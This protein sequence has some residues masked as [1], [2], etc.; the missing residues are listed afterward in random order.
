MKLNTCHILSTIIM[1]ISVKYL[2]VKCVACQI[3]LA[4]TNHLKQGRGLYGAMGTDLSYD[5][6]RIILKSWPKW[7]FAQLF[8]GFPVLFM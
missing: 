7:V 4:V 3:L 8:I 2:L 5:K 1:L 6:S